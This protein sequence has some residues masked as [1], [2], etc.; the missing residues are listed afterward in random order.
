MA[1][2]EDELIAKRT[3]VPS[4][5][6][7]TLKTVSRISNYKTVFIYDTSTLLTDTVDQPQ[8]WHNA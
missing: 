3:S 8:R 7:K 6:K 1:L 5:Q 2:R 4:V